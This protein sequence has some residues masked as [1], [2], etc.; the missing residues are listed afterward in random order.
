M[1]SLLLRLAGR[2]V[3]V[4]VVLSSLPTY[5]MGAMLLPPSIVDA[6]DARRRAFLWFGSDNVSG[7]RCLVAWEQVCTPKEDSGLGSSG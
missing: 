1:E 2:A 4:N 3:L 6:I 7:A 5:A